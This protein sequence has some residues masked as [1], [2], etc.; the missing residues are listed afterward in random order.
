MSYRT[1]L[2]DRAHDVLTVTINRPKSLNA[3][4]REVIKEL[5]DVAVTLGGEP[6]SIRGVILAGAGGKAFVAG[7]D[8]RGM[9]DIDPSEARQ[10]AALGQ[11][12]MVRLEELPVP[13]IACV[14]GYALGGGCELAMACDFIYASDGAV[15]GQPEVSLG[16]VPGFGGSIR[17]Q[18]LV[19]PARARELIFTG[20]LVDAAEAYRIGLVNAVFADREG[21]LAAARQT[22]SEVARQSALAVSLA[23]AGV[24]RARDM[25]FSAALKLEQESFAT[26]F[27]SDDARARIRNF[28]DG[29]T[30][31][32]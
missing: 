20:R 27:G 6:G 7:A 23:K 14:D 10:L 9:V 4:S 17:L 3:L 13:V 26:A 30:A 28:A 2:T 22:I 5:H 21:M 24:N 19:G 8:V 11:D 15:F 12:L 25:D 29:R 32:Q 16:I 31:G 18:Q 1:L